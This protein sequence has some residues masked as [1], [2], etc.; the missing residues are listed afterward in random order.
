MWLRQKLTG[1]QW[2]AVSLFSQTEGV[3]RNAKKQPCYIPIKSL[4][5]KR[6]EEGMEGG[7]DRKQ[8][9]MILLHITTFWVWQHCRLMRRDTANTNGCQPQLNLFS[10]NREYLWLDPDHHIILSTSI[11]RFTACP[12]LQTQTGPL[13]TIILMLFHR[14]LQATGEQQ[15]EP[16]QHKC[17]DLYGRYGLLE[18]C[19]VRALNSD[20]SSWA[21]TAEREL[22]HIFKDKNVHRI[23]FLFSR[24]PAFPCPRFFSSY[25]GWTLYFEHCCFKNIIKNIVHSF[26]GFF[27]PQINT[28]LMLLWACAAGE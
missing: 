27:H 25:K 11:R 24:N 1:W 9:Q 7:N 21:N 16:V 12:S 5:N 15:M 26:G 28:H 22:N 13:D 19:R 20:V 17:N 14:S 3:G 6:G 10:A 8:K 18:E 23:C 2:Y 4:R